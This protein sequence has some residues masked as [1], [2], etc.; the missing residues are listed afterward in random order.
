MSVQT[1]LRLIPG[2]ARRAASRVALVAAIYGVLGLPVL[3][4]SAE[5]I[6]DA[7]Q[8][9]AARD[10]APSSQAKVE[11]LIELKFRSRGAEVLTLRRRLVELGDLAP[12]DVADP[13]LYDKALLAA[14]RA[15]Q[16]RHGLRSTGNVG[17]ATLKILRAA[18]TKRTLNEQEAPTSRKPPAATA[19]AAPKGPLP[20]PPK[21]P[22]PIT[23]LAEPVN[24]PGRPDFGAGA[25][26]RID[27]KVAELRALASVGY[28][29]VPEGRELVYKGRGPAV[30]EL[31]RR[32]VQAGALAPDEAT[33]DHFD[34]A[35]V[36]ALRRFQAQN[37]INPTGN[38]GP[39]TRAA[40]NATVEDHVAALVFSRARLANMSWPSD[41]KY[42]VANIA[43]AS[44]ELIADGALVH[45]QVAVF[46]RVT[47]ATPELNDR[48]VSVDF[49]PGWTVPK[50]IAERDLLP[51]ERKNPGFL[52][53]QGMTVVDGKGAPL[54]VTHGALTRVAAGSAYI[55]Q[56]P[57]PDNALGA[58]RFMLTNGEAIF[59]HDTPSRRAFRKAR[60]DRFLSSGCVRLSEP[61]RLANFVLEGRDDWGADRIQQAIAAARAPGAQLETTR[62]TPKRVVPVKI[63]YIPAWVD[64]DGRLQTRTDIYD[65]LA[66]ASASPTV[67]SRAD[68][69]KPTP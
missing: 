13:E 7:G 20:A 43:N 49:A 19:P 54:S 68:V 57:G 40:L 48:I 29:R 53:R 36:N 26:E 37:G 15:F 69:A 58:V 33:L 4:A 11:G 23:R 25:L 62:V 63:V 34:L 51:K 10:A 28:V 39:Q 27:T 35:L 66:Q 55:R 45:R 22:K 9:T 67:R 18:N 41:G 30:I 14:V 8:P 46:G 42:I 21:P 50:S 44:V 47:R 16:V 3:S 64:A 52:E 5:V 60:N 12:G 2:I 59:L 24:A 61:E 65:K 6:L 38:L 17:P 56:R 31:R 32:L 1:A